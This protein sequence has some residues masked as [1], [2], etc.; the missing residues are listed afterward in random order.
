MPPVGAEPATSTYAAQTITQL[1]K[2]AD[3]A[4]IVAFWTFL[5]LSGAIRYFIVIGRDQAFYCYRTRAGIISSS[6]A[7]RYFTDIE[8][9]HVLLP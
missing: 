5:P 6:N 4:K 7:L 8:R 2:L 3:N 9:A 1:T